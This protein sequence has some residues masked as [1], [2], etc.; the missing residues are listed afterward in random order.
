VK[1]HALVSDIGVKVGAI[2][3]CHRRLVRFQLLLSVQLDALVH[4]G[5]RNTDFGLHL[6]KLVPDGFQIGQTSLQR[7]ALHEVLPGELEDC[8]GAR[9][10]VDRD[11][12][13]LL[14][15]A[16]GMNVKSCGARDAYGQDASKT[17]R[18]HD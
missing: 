7:L 14:N 11:T 18:I 5:P 6:G 17:P 2:V 3:L 13:T 15:M 10:A 9:D 12:E 8:L 1:L 4:E 16:V